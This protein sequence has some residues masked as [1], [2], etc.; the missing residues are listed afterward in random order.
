MVT[1]IT[2]GA[3]G[4]EYMDHVL[5]VEWRVGP[6]DAV[7]QGDVVAVVETAKAATEVEAPCDGVMGPILAPVG[8]EV[9]VGARLGLIG[10][11]AAD[12]ADAAGDQPT[13]E[14]PTP[15]PAPEINADAG[16]DAGAE[17]D[18]GPADRR[19]PE[20]GDGARLVASPAARRMAAETRVDLRVVAGTGPGGRIKRRDVM[21]IL[22]AGAPAGEAGLPAVAGSPEGDRPLAVRRS[23]PAN[24]TPVLL[25]HGFAGDST[26]WHALEREL[27]R[28]HPVLRLDLPCHGRSPRRRYRCFRDFAGDVIATVAGWDTGPLHVVG[29]S[30]GGAVALAL[31][32]QRPQAVRSL[33]LIAPVGLGSEI[34]G[35]IIEGLCRAS[36]VESL[37]PWLRH[38][39]VDPAR[40]GDAYA[41]AAMAAR[42]DPALR[43]AQGALAAMLFPDGTQAVNVTPLLRRVRVSLRMIWGR[44]D[45]VVPWRHAL[46]APG[47][48]GLHLLPAVG[49][50]PHLEAPETVLRVLEDLITCTDDGVST[51]TSATPDGSLL[52]T[53]EA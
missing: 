20:A 31:A 45:A 37:E 28:R 40:V 21:A 23:G 3:V 4:G 52:S 12:A 42:A 9:P 49:H 39:V 13:P 50:L 2:T 19:V 34:D 22:R 43:L 29:H 11:D 10:A 53:Q 32:D 30:L 6:G 7:R 48:A 5:V 24:G 17:S 16:A 18:P 47:H 8:T 1:A 26:V 51:V 36:R 41:R 27:A 14:P 38:L 35:G 46:A 25:L 15:V 44:A 33:S